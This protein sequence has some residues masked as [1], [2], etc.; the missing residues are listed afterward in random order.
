[1]LC[2]GNPSINSSKNTSTFSRHSSFT[3]NP[4]MLN[5]GENLLHLLNKNYF[6]FDTNP[7]VDLRG[8]TI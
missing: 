1:M 8:T 3:P 6:K 7:T 2:H 5:F 4:M